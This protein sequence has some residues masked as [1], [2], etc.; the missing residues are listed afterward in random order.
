MARA[1]WNHAVVG[2]AAALLLVL[3][4][5]LLAGCARAGQLAPAGPELTPSAAEL[6]AA[7]ADSGPQPLVAA[8]APPAL[9]TSGSGWREE[10]GAYSTAAEEDAFLWFDHPVSGAF[11]L[12]AEVESDW[13]NYGEA[14]VVAY[15]DGEGWTPGCLIFNVT[16]YWQAI[17]AHSIYD[18]DAEWLAQRMQDLDRAQRRHRLM[19]RAEGDQALLYVDGE[20]AASAALGPGLGREGHIGLVKYGGSAAVTFRDIV[21]TQGGEAAAAPATPAAAGPVARAPATRTPSPT[22][23]AT[24]TRTATLTLTPSPTEAPTRTETPPPTETPLPTDPPPPP[25][26][27]PTGMLVDRAPGGAGE[28]VLLNGTD[29]D[30]LVI[31]TGMDEVAVKTGYIRAGESFRMA[32][33]HDGTYL[34]FYSKGEAFSEETYRFTQSA[35]YQKMDTEI[36]FET[37]ATQYTIWEVTL[38]GV[39]GGTVGS[40]G[41]DPEDFP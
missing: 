1:G 13:D 9:R 36:P 41:V 17:R 24:R 11:Q 3:C 32:G 6:A 35:T 21:L 28:L 7:G 12:S 25:F 20:L 37:T 29:A 31:L 5:L 39:A 18:P 27:P 33:I 8:F 23:T 30:A 19:I 4:A 38:Y 14:M 10:G 26:R 34:L 16:G 2:A 40:E 22:R 15:A